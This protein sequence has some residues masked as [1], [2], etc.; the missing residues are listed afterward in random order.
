MMRGRSFIAAALLLAGLCG[1]MSAAGGLRPETV[2]AWDAYVRAT[3]ARIAQEGPTARGRAE[4]GVIEV[5]REMSRGA[6]GRPF[7][8]P[9]GMVHHWRG[10]VFIPRA[11]VD[12]IIARVANPGAADTDQEDVVAARVLARG[13][14]SLRLFLRLRRS[15]IV[16]A[17][18]NTE[19]DVRYGRQPDGRA[20]SR[21]TATRIAE[22]AEPDTPRE[23][24]RL[25]GDDRGFLWRLNSYWRYEGVPGGVLVECESLSLSR[26]APAAVLGAARPIIDHV[27]SGSMERTLLAL[28]TRFT[29]DGQG[30]GR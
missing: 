26:S 3:E 9:G 7:E 6:D 10:R 13:P 4:T 23:S 11:S 14:G 8:V 20:W 30:A 18:Y 1:P 21:S 27:A 16:T 29:R 15:Q 28:R 24:E 25:P 17:V 22:V 19:H 2:A 5:T 12:E